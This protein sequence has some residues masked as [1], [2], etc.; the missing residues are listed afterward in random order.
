MRMLSIEFVR[1]IYKA[2]II[3]V[4]GYP[5]PN[6]VKES[7]NANPP[8]EIGERVACHQFFMLI[9]VYSMRELE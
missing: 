9:I 2:V 3:A 5:F 8:H 6:F 1:G 4:T 7:V